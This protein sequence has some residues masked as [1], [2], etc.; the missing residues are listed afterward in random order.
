MRLG[1]RIEGQREMLL[2]IAGKKVAEPKLAAQTT[3]VT[4]KR[5]AG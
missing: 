3:K 1:S 4:G 5:K 2:P